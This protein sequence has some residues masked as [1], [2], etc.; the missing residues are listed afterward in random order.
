MKEVIKEKHVIYD[1]GDGDLPKTLFAFRNKACAQPYGSGNY[2]SPTPSEIARFFELTGWTQA[3]IARL[4][5]LFYN[6]TGCS[7]VR[8]WKDTSPSNNRAIP[9]ATWRHLLCCAGV[10]SCESDVSS[11]VGYRVGA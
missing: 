6:K 8:K 10:V 4:A 9:Y 3:D 1:V 7:A 5:G 2:E 11:S